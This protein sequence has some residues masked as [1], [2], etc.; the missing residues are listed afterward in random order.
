LLAT[1]REHMTDSTETSR[2]SLAIL[3]SNWK[4]LETDSVNAAITRAFGPSRDPDAQF[5][6]PVIEGAQY[7]VKARGSMVIIHNNSSPYFSNSGAVANCVEGD[8]LLAS[9]VRSHAGW[10]SVDVIG[11]DE[12]DD[13]QYD[14]IGMLLAELAPDDGSAVAL[15]VP[16]EGVLIRFDESR[17]KQLRGPSTMSLLGFEE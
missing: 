11:S 7:M 13:E 14:T 5:G 6:L 10:M 8:D 12:S 3:L 9:A 4:P 1:P 16:E 17:R 15:F 2:S